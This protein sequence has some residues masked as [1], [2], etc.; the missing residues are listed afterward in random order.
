MKRSQA[1]IDCHIITYLFDQLKYGIILLIFQA[2]THVLKAYVVAIIDLLF[3]INCKVVHILVIRNQIRFGSDE[4]SIQFHEI[5]MF[6]YALW[7]QEQRCVH[8]QINLK[9]SMLVLAFLNTL[10]VL[11]G[12]LPQLFDS[13]CESLLKEIE[14]KSLFIECLIHGPLEL[15]DQ[16]Y[17]SCDFEWLL[18]P[19]Y[20]LVRL[21]L[22]L[23]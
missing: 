16:R 14:I 12:F 4:T 18:N 8:R 9:S 10:S 22:E 1:V 6:E 7:N 11:F 13:S 2:E 3:I 15:V 17:Q 5:L 23:L 19:H 21:R 20:H